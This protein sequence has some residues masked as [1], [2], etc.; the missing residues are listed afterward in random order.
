MLPL[1]SSR[2]ATTK[3]QAPSFKLTLARKEQAPDLNSTY[4]PKI[5]KLKK[6]GLPSSSQRLFGFVDGG[7]LYQKVKLK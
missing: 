4:C 2:V 1:V 6:A 5:F 7:D 3:C